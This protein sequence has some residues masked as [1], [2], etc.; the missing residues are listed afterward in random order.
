VKGCEGRGEGKAATR[1]RTRDGCSHATARVT[2]VN[3]PLPILFSLP[4]PF[5]ASPSSLHPSLLSLF[6]G[7]IPGAILFALV[8]AISLATGRR[9]F[10]AR[11]A[12]ALG[13]FPDQ[14]P[15]SGP[16]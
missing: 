6:P 14:R 11:D 4:S 16:L 5:P 12:T 15:L 13:C 2:C 1:T 3:I 7:S 9:R 10:L 8:P